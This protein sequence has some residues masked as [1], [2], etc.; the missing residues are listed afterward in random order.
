MGRRVARKYRGRGKGVEV[1]ME[2]HRPSR[3]GR[4]EGGGMDVDINGI[5]AGESDVH[6]ADRAKVSGIINRD[7]VAPRLI[8]EE[9]QCRWRSGIRESSESRIGRACQFEVEV[10]RGCVVGEFE[11]PRR[12]D[13]N[14]RIAAAVERNRPGRRQRKETRPRGG[15]RKSQKGEQEKSGIRG[16]GGHRHDS[17]LFLVAGVGGFP[18][19]AKIAPQRPYHAVDESSGAVD[20][21]CLAACDEGERQAPTSPLAAGESRN[22]RGNSEHLRTLAAQRLA[23]QLTPAVHQPYTVRR[24]AAKPPKPARSR[25]GRRP[26][27]A[28]HHKP[29]AASCM[30]LILIRG[31]SLRLLHPE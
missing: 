18:I 4:E 14:R 10:G 5:H 30:R 16:T 3:Q 21:S 26:A 23:H 9:G 13:G 27:A 15:R 2:G 20:T 31:L 28:A 22:A 7:L 6:H 1:G 11:R 12:A 25:V 8:M 29:R 19:A 24:P 17:P